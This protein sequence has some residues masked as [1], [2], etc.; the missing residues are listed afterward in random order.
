MLCFEDV[1]VDDI[2][3]SKTPCHYCALCSAIKAILFTVNEKS[4]YMQWNVGH[5]VLLVQHI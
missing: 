4:V 3:Y 5:M 1:Y 2:L